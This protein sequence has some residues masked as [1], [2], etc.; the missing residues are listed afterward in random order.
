MRILLAVLLGLA[1]AGGARAQES[2]N[3]Y[4][5]L[6][7]AHL[8]GAEGLKEIIDSV[9]EKSGGK[10]RFQLNL[11]G[12]LPIN[13]SDITQ[14]V[15]DDIV[16]MASDGF[17]L[18]NVTVGGILRLP[19]LI[20]N[21]EQYA[22]AI[23]VMYPYM[24]KAYAERGVTMLGTYY[25]PQ[26]TIF[27]TKPVTSLAGLSGMKFRMTS[28]EQALFLRAFGASGITISPPEV[29]SALQRGSVD[30]ALTAAAGGG[31]VWGD[32]FTHNYQ[33]GTDFFQAFIIVN[34]ARFEKLSPELRQMLRDK[35]AEVT[36]RNSS[37]MQ[38]EEGETLD[39]FRARGMVITKATPAEVAEA[40]KPMREIWL[41][42]AKE[43]GPVHEKALAEVMAA[44]GK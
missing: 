27:G 3:A 20:E 31:R 5:Y 10:I 41:N 25:Y 13:A 11:A 24:E 2:W 15:G 28:P 19:M 12:S 17:F 33:L 6:P 44:V 32:F 29:P 36:P 7:A 14:A 42:W 8:A 34:T 35:V 9:Q 18:G 21:N 22:K 26:I 43:R 16:Q 37:R 40:A 1:L 4:T 30:G 39:K 23:E 38:R